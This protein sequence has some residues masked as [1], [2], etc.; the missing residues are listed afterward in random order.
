MIRNKRCKR[1]GVNVTVELSREEKRVT[2]EKE[3][4]H[5]GHSPQYESSGKRNDI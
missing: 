3:G 4:N 5:G 1:T 2:E